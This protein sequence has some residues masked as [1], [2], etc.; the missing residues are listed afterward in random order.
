MKSYRACH[1]ASSTRF[2]FLLAAFFLLCAAVPACTI[3][4]LT[5]TNR[6]LFCNNEDWS[7]FKTRVWFVPGGRGTNGCAYVGFA[8]GVAQGGVNTRGLAYDWVAGYNQKLDPE[9][10][11]K[12]IKG[13]LS[14]RMLETCATVE[15]VVAF[16]R[17]YAE[18]AFAMGKTLVADRTGASVIIGA[19]DGHVV[20][21]RES[22]C[23]GFGYGQP[24]LAKMLTPTT[25][26]TLLNAATI[27][28]AARQ[29][30]Q[31]ATKYSNVYDLNSGD[32]FLF[33]NPGRDDMVTIHL[34]EELKK[35]KH[36][37][38]MPNIKEE[39]KQSPRPVFFGSKD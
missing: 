3:F 12:R 4:V 32:I 10:G 31:Y 24:A 18:P 25:E 23:R 36:G 13:N 22:K 7:D 21:E 17:A 11:K 35:G 20:F 34:T 33:P 14:V 5:D 9:P 19:K 6:V 8:D 38:D 39:L 2:G 29:E 37:Y 27:L 1:R 28:R 15:D 30:G 16:Y 26:P